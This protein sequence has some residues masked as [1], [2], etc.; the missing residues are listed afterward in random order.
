MIQ[1]KK[2]LQ[3]KIISFALSCGTFFSAF[4]PLF[5]ASADEFSAAQNGFNGD[6]KNVSADAAFFEAAR[7]SAN[8]S[9]FLPSSYE[10]YLP[11]SEPSSVAVTE[12][13]TAIADGL[14]IYVYDR[15]AG[16]YS[17]YEHSESTDKKITQ[18][19]F[20]ENGTLY[21]S[22]QSMD[23][24]TLSVSTLTASNTGV[25]CIAFDI[26]GGS[27]YYTTFSNRSLNIDSR[28]LSDLSA[29]SVSL[30]SMKDTTYAPALA[31]N[32]ETLY[33]TNA[34]I[35]LSRADDPGY[36]KKLYS[37]ASS[38]PSAVQSV[39]F[40]G[41]YCYYTD[42][43]KDLYACRY[44][45][46]DATSEKI[47]ENCSSVSSPYNGMIYVVSG[48]TI[49]QLNAETR[50][51]TSYEISSS[52]PSDGRLSSAADCVLSGDTLVALDPGEESDG[53]PRLHVLSAATA[54]DRTAKT[55]HIRT[56][57]AKYIAS[58][59]KTACIATGNADG[60]LAVYDLSA[61]PADGSKIAPIA[62]FSAKNGETFVG[63]TCVY[64]A[65]YAATGTSFY[66]LLPNDASADE[67]LSYRLS[68]RETGKV[69]K[70]IASDIFGTIYVAHSDLVYPYT[71]SEFIDETVAKTPADAV[72]KLPSST[73]ESTPTKLLVDFD[74]NVY[75]LQGSSIVKCESTERAVNGV[76]AAVSYPL[77][78][79][80]TK[81]FVFS[82]TSE[83]P[84]LSVAFGAETGA[85]YVLYN[86]DFI[87]VTYDLPLPTLESIE[88]SGTDKTLFA[89]ESAV[90][91]VVSCP[92]K[93]LLIRFDSASLRDAAYFPYVSHARTEKRISALALAQTDRFMLL[94]V[95]DESKNDYYTALAEKSVCSQISSDEYLKDPPEEFLNG[96]KGYVTNALHLYKYPY[97][98][99]LFTVTYLPRN[100]EIT[101]L[102]R[103]EK[104]DWLYYQVEYTDE[105]GKTSTGY[106]P[107]AYVTDTK[108]S[109]PVADQ[110]TLGGENNNRDLVWRLVYIVLGTLAVCILVDYLILRKYDKD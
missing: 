17:Y 110:T 96:G 60:T 45:S 35:Y 67:N 1:K 29:S 75:A 69:N 36:T 38:S 13:Y 50:N 16:S 59:G 87:A 92:A 68:S 65:Y 99:E 108:G 81:T 91:S 15:L 5:S 72:A 25:S 84:V 98:T 24:Y 21:F 73:G 106:L 48:K 57:N 109:T 30:A 41:D 94:A 56:N 53:D 95:Y 9:L 88:V 33:Y 66:A 77:N 2:K 82:Q 51:F 46:A 89:E 107:A 43:A 44:A 12:N 105:T 63:V 8:N 18:V 74:R 80:E 64:G 61:T 86:G 6:L 49:K 27:I 34:G 10:E 83:T 76:S 11:L 22:V 78:D 26:H 4:S 55:L 97:L 85:A 42:T 90:F 71:E 47:A 7:D 40:Y 101:V 100:A 62:E 20:D 32:G 103:V 58:D 52:S 31:H 93:T 28:P 19:Q 54:A 23:L 37:S 3:K 39:T 102:K 104:L 70:M 14:K 79:S